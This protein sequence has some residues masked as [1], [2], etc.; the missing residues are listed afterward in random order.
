MRIHAMGRGEH[1]EYKPFYF[2]WFCFRCGPKFTRVEYLTNPDKFNARLK[3]LGGV[4]AWSYKP[5]DKIFLFWGAQVAEKSFRKINS[6]SIRQ[7]RCHIDSLY[8]YSGSDFDFVVDSYQS[9]LNALVHLEKKNI[10]CILFQLQFINGG[11]R[12]Q[13]FD[14]IC[15]C[16]YQLGD[17]C[18]VI[19]E[20]HLYSSP[21][22]YRIGLKYCANGSSPKYRANLYVSRAGETNKTLLSMSTYVYCGQIIDLNDQKY[23]ANF[24][25]KAQAL[26]ELQDRTLSN[27][28]AR[29]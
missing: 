24:I 15:E 17:V 11:G 7:T 5:T 26:S 20:V 29:T 6:R 13:L 28:Q 4:T 25:G 8:E 2:V 21:Q 16:I 1:T 27:I 14:R 12:E 23:I 19:E 22:F 18:L 3:D 10:S 9:F